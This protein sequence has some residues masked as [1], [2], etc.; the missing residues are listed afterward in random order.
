MVQPAPRHLQLSP[1]SNE[2]SNDLLESSVGQKLM[3]KT[4]SLVPDVLA[5]LGP[6]R[7]R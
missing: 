5:S 3:N 2:S 7:G 4:I 6:V 1:A